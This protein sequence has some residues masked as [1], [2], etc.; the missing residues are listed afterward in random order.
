MA[1]PI[2]HYV[3]LVTIQTPGLL[4]VVN[5]QQVPFQLM[6]LSIALHVLLGFTL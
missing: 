4:A 6:A 3:Q 1:L 2:V 5:A